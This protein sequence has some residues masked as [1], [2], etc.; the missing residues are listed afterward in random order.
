VTE[1]SDGAGVVLDREGYEYSVNAK[2]LAPGIDG[3]V[4]GDFVEGYVK[5]F[6]TVQDIMPV[7][8]QK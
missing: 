8:Y 7:W 2:N 6:E 3:L 5:D 4:A 1:W